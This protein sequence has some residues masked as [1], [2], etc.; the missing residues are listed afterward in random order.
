MR[1]AKVRCFFAAAHLHRQQSGVDGAAPSH[2]ASA[3]PEPSTAHGSALNGQ[4]QSLM[5]ADGVS[6]GSGVVP[7]WV[8]GTGQVQRATS[9]VSDLLR[10]LSRAGM[11]DEDGAPGQ[12]SLPSL[13]ATETD[14]F[15]GAS[16][17]PSWL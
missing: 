13:R 10:P 3:L 14:F 15:P 6:T 7:A 12:H 4:A 5:V 8:L 11:M 9:C 16:T 1:G 2:S 17:E